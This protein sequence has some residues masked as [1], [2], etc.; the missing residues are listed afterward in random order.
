[1]NRNNQ[2]IVEINRFVVNT[3]IL[4]AFVSPL[5]AIFIL[6]EADHWV[7][8]VQAV[9][10]IEAIIASSMV[11]TRTHRLS[12]KAE[13]AKQAVEH[14]RV[15][16]N[17]KNLIEQT[18]SYLLYICDHAVG[19]LDK[20]NSANLFPP[21]LGSNKGQ[22]SSYGFKAADIRRSMSLFEKNLDQLST[23]SFA[24]I[25]DPVIASKIASFISHSK[26]L[27]EEISV[28]WDVPEYKGEMPDNNE[29]NYESDSFSYPPGTPNLTQSQKRI[30]LSHAI[31]RGYMNYYFCNDFPN[32]IAEVYQSLTA[33]LC[34]K[35]VVRYRS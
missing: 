9:G 17:L 32:R 13:R 22:W 8:W 28:G 25:G 7:G 34:A 19:G 30:G 29:R 27:V 23:L 12:I 26:T 31:A 6:A 1:M 20:K 15:F 24:E 10:S 21:G 5:G 33:E 4:L 18:Y 2:V 16:T 11:A 14:A 35:S 3:L